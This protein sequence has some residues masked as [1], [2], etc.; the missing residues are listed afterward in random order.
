[1]DVSAANNLDRQ[2]DVERDLQGEAAAT[3]DHAEGVRAFLQKR[4]AVFIGKR[5]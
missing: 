4:P 1:L 3:P 2:L 5:S